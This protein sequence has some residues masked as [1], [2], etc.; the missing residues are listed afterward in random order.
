[1]AG[2][3]V[4]SRPQAVVWT[5]AYET[6]D[7]KYVPSGTE[8]DDFIILSDHNRSEISMKK[9]RIE[10]RRRMINGTM[11]SYHIADK[12]EFSW[13]WDMFPSRAFSDA[14]VFSASGVLTNSIDDY[15]VDL[16][17]GGV[18]IVEWYENHQGPFYMLLAYDKYNEF[19]ISPYSHLNEYNEVVQVYFSS[20][21][22]EVVKR[23][24]TNHDLWNISVTLEE[25]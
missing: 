9:Q 20:F 1:M 10:N 11:R 23:G 13:S 18:D 15:V 25:V 8:F 19:S 14:P 16:A 4:Y 17:A 2:R 3:S 24:G 22:T 5:D 7:A 21:D 12:R 6:S